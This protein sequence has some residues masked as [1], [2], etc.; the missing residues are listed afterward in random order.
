MNA[1]ISFM[2]NEQRDSAIYI[3]IKCHRVP[4]DLGVFVSDSQQFWLHSLN[5]ALNRALK[6][7]FMRVC[8]F[9]IRVSSL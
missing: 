4:W 7:T 6:I 2:L 5:S 3:E 1:F 9:W 8:L